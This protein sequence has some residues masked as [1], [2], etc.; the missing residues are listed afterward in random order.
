MREL[1]DKTTQFIGKHVKKEELTV[2]VEFVVVF[3][4]AGDNIFSNQPYN[5]RKNAREKG[6]NKNT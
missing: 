4:F 5:G 2:A 3:Y 6:A 1:R